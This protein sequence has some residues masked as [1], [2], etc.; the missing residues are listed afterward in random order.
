MIDQRVCTLSGQL[1]EG[2]DVGVQLGA[3]RFEFIICLE[4][5]DM[6]LPV[7]AVQ[8]IDGAVPDV[9]PVPVAE[10]QFGMHFIGIQQDGQDIGGRL[11][12]RVAAGMDL[13]VNT[14]QQPVVLVILIL[15]FF[16]DNLVDQG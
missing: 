16:P 5:D 9:L 12:L 8:G 14:L 4:V 3:V 1:P 15:G 13:P 2:F 10:G 7:P 6:P 11:G